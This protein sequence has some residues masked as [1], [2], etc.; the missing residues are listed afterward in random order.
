[1]N[2][3]EFL[4]QIM[5]WE[6]IPEQEAGLLDLVEAATVPVKSVE[7]RIEAAVHRK[8]V[9]RSGLLQVEET[10][11]RN[12]ASLEFEDLR[13]LRKGRILRRKARNKVNKVA[14]KYQS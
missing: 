5:E 9:T 4:E 7:E 14:N 3:E 10:V 6:I 2:Y 13:K 1:M 8:R 12:L 11:R